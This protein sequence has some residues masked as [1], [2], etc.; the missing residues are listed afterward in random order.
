MLQL[1]EGSSRI[2]TDL[3]SSVKRSEFIEVSVS[4]LR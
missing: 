2:N 1:K 4:E 3:V